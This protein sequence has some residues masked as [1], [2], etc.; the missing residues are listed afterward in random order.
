MLDFIVWSGMHARQVELDLSPSL[1]SNCGK[2]DIQ[3]FKD[4]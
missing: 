1:E 3:L 2:A 4:D